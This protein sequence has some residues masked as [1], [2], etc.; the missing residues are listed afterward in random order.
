MVALDISLGYLLQHYY[1]KMNTGEASRITYSITKASEEMF[2]FGSSRAN[3]NY[4]PD[5]LEDSLHLSAYNSGTDGQNILFDYCV[6]QSIRER[7]KPKIIILDLNINEFEESRLGYDKLNVLLPYY[8]TNKNI[9]PVI[10][11]RSPYEK[12][13]TMSNLYRYNSFALTILINNIIKRKDD[14]RKGYVPLYNTINT[15]LE[16]PMAVKRL[17]LDTVKVNVFR[18]FLK[19]AKKDNCRVFVFISPIFQKDIPVSET[20]LTAEAI[21]KQESVYFKSYT[22]F[23]VFNDHADYFQDRSHLNNKG[24]EV[25]TKIISTEIK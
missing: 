3:H 10:N 6:L 11:L 2:I 15:T 18:S 1:L 7:T 4:I 8:K 5:I 16:K 9:Q 12:F 21:C 13:K 25:Y 17:P 22:G 23:P 24:A 20:V 14:S 19:E